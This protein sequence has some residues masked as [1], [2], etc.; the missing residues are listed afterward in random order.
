M[1]AMISIGGIFGLMITGLIYPYFFCYGC[2]FAV[3]ACPIGLLEHSFVDLHNGLLSGLALLVYLFG[4]LSLVGILSGRA[5]CGWGCPI[6]LLQ[7]ATNKTGISD[8]ACSKLAP[9]G[10]NP[11]L[12]LVKYVILVLI[13]LPSYVFLKLMYTNLCPVGGLTGTLPTLLLFGGDWQPSNFF[14]IK[15]LSVVLFT[16]LV[17]LV[18]RG[19]CKYLCPVGAFLAPWN[20]V[21]GIK[22]T[23]DE[24]KCTECGLCDRS[25]PMDMKDV[26]RRADMECILCGRCV[27]ACKNDALKIHTRFSKEG[28]RASATWLVTVALIVALLSVGIW[29]GGY[30]R[31]EEIN[32]IPCLGCLAL[33]PTASMDFEF[34][35][36]VAQSAFV[37]TTLSSRPVFLHYRTDACSA[38][39]DM[40]PVVE[41]LEETYDDDVVF[42]H[43]NLDHSTGTEKASYDL[44]DVKGTPQRRGGVPMFT[45]ITLNRERNETLPYYATSYGIQEESA[46]AESIGTALELYELWGGGTT[47][48]EEGIGLRVEDPHGSVLPNGTASFTV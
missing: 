36:D 10:V 42:I 35:T 40:E 43:I 21:S 33:N 44:Y 4:F 2:P 47:S 18:G 8:H 16:L 9:K 7:D 20:K 14:G 30:E 38:C 6:G 22:L 3:G 26:G 45:V 1:F 15:I 25:C 12:K 48:V 29:G 41:R 5:F 39:D 13:P 31:S 17:L 19:W 28:A 46:L 24:E 27:E 37:S 34:L 11:R 32:T 23:R